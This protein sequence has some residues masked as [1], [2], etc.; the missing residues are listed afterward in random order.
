[1]RRELGAYPLWL[2]LWHWSNAVLFVVL[3][4]TGLSMHYSRPAPSLGFRGDVLIHNAAGAVLTLFYC[5]FLYGNLRLGNGRYYHIVAGDIEPGLLLQTRYYLWGIFV[6]SPHPYPHSE[7]RKFNP[8]QKLF[9]LAVMYLLFPILT[10]TGWALL[11]PGR[12]PEAM[13][14]VP[15]I[16]FWALAHTYIGYFLS[17]FMVIHVYLGTTGTTPGQLFRLMWFGETGRPEH[18]PT[19][20]SPDS[21]DRPG[22]RD[23][24]PVTTP[25]E[26]I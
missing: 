23:S 21:G 14:G 26:H 2:R 10:V 3:L 5:L 17:L 9:Y 24:V 4:I 8:L 15:G 25:E 16:G 1:M 7:Q 19:P 13:F 20:R 11:S 18:L 22:N 6:G 12:L